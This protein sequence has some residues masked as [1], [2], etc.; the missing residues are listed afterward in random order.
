M[1]VKKGRGRLAGAGLIALGVLVLCALGVFWP[2][3]ATDGRKSDTVSFTVGTRTYVLTLEDVTMGEPRFDTPDVR[4]LCTRTRMVVPL[5]GSAAQGETPPETGTVTLTVDET[6]AGTVFYLSSDSPA[7]VRAVLTTQDDDKLT[8]RAVDPDD[9]ETAEPAAPRFGMA[10]SPDSA[11]YLEGRRGASLSVAPVRTDR[12]RTERLCVQVPR[13][14][15]IACARGRHAVAFAA[16]ARRTGFLL[17]HRDR[18][19]ARQLGEPRG[20]Y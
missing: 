18:P 2:R 6:D 7:G 5:L 11:L 20:A 4:P 15:R 1:T 10:Y 3:R 14:G 17:G 12:A 13:R 16:A 19:H 8:V 9:E